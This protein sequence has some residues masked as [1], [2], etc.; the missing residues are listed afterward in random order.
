MRPAYST[1]REPPHL[2]EIYE[3]V[4]ATLVL[5]GG[6][7]AWYLARE[8]YHL[9]SHQVAELAAYVAIALTAV[10]SSIYLL[11]TSRSRR[12]KQWP[13]P[14]LFVPARKDERNT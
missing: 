12:E 10:Y 1:G 11:A 14:P 5:A 7:F 4:I 3:V 9:T 2:L 8:R 13:H 6:W